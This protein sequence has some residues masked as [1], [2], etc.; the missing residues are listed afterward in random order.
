[1]DE[2]FLGTVHQVRFPASAPQKSVDD[3][4]NRKDQDQNVATLTDM[5]DIRKER[6]IIQLD[7]NRPE[8]HSFEPTPRHDY[9]SSTPT[10][11]SRSHLIFHTSTTVKQSKTKKCGVDAAVFRNFKQVSL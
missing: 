6:E 5:W 4:T 7:K 9:Y 1:M 2:D 10:L 11:S 3:I 8:E